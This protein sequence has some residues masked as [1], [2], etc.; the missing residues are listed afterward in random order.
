MSTPGAGV[1]PK[2]VVRVGKRMRNL[3]RKANSGV[4]L[5]AYA[6]ASSKD[7]DVD[8]LALALGWLDMKAGD[9]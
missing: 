4:S 1:D 6:L 8:V 9:L 7:P 2:K 3:H 5:R